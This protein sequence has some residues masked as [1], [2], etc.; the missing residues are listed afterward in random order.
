MFSL[1]SFNILTLP[2][3]TSGYS[4]SGPPER[5]M[6]DYGRNTTYTYEYTYCA[7]KISGLPEDFFQWFPLPTNRTVLDPSG[8]IFVQEVKII[9][10]NASTHV[11]YQ[12][13]IDDHGNHVLYYKF[14]MLNGDSW[15]FNITMNVTL[16]EIS[17]KP[18][19]SVDFSMYNVSDPDYFRYTREEE[20]INKSYNPIHDEALLLNASDPFTTAKN[21]YDFVTNY[22]T[23]DY[24]M[25]GDN[26][27]E[28]AIDNKKGDCTEFSY[29]M[30]A[31]LRACGIPA[32]VLRG[33]VI[34]DSSKQGAVVDYDPS[35]NKEW[36][37]YT[38][39]NENS[40]ESNL[41]GHSYLE[42]FIPGYGWV[43]ADPTWHNIKDYSSSADNI[44]LTTHAGVWIG[45]GINPSF[46]AAFG[47]HEYPFFPFVASKNMYQKFYHSIRVVSH[48]ATEFSFNDLFAFFSDNATF[49][50][51]GA[52]SIIGIILVVFIVK[53]QKSSKNRNRVHVV[54]WD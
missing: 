24:N 21:I 5:I 33:F 25:A 22:L 15:Y 26:G 44:H 20:Y 11:D 18:N 53:R 9:N 47:N 13:S 27:A 32:R 48:E 2:I 3:N 34:A 46:D 17:W 50:L 14:H 31:L 36:N 19:R 6:F 49:I 42:Y 35:V 7:N 43:M 4:Y 1:F 40:M 30:V 23:Y 45:E 41:T 10:K 54:Y 12:E 37:F 16:R 39:I 29:L 38:L 8:A 28:W 51:I 52:F